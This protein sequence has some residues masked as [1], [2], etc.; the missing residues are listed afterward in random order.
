MPAPKHGAIIGKAGATLKDIQSK[1][2][3]YIEVPKRGDNTDIITVSGTKAA[4]KRA[5]DLI[6]ETLGYPVS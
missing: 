5:V 4:V 3:A 6:S 1:S 2:L